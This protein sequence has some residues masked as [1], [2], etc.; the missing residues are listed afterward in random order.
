MFQVQGDGE[1]PGNREERDEADQGGIQSSAG[2]SG[3]S[4]FEIQDAVADDE[5]SGE[6][7]IGLNL[8]GERQNH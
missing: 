2:T 6:P 5:F 4:E 1:E 3:K 7:D 8:D